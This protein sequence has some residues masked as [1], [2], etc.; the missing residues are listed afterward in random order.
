MVPT[1]IIPQA[2]RRRLAATRMFARRPYQGQI[3][4]RRHRQNRLAWANNHR[5]WGRQ[6]WRQVFFTD[7]SKF[8]LSFADGNKRVY[9]R[10]GDRF[11]Q[12][13]VLEH[14][15]WGGGGIM[16]WAGISADQNTPLHAVRGRLNGN[17]YRDTILA[18]LVVPLMTQHGLRLFQ[19]DNARAHVARV[20]TDFLRQQ[21]INALPW[22]SLSPGPEVIKLFSCSTQLSMKF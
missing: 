3:L 20:S 16:V 22:P 11:A 13:Y 19:Q 6:Q 21:H 7:E 12:C 8:N 18:P 1:T 14:N 5:G 10:G 4:T 17:A 2:V 9:R 15:R